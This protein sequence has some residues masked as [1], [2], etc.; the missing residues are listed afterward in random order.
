MLVLICMGGLSPG[1]T[2]AAENPFNVDCFVGWNGCYRPGTWTPLE[3]GITSTLTENFDGRVHVSV[4]QDSVNRMN[5]TQSFVLTVDQPTHIPLVTKIAFGADELNL[6]LT[7]TRGRVRRRLDIGLWDFSRNNQLLKPVNREDLFV[8]LVGRQSFG[9]LRLPEE[10]QCVYSGQSRTNFGRVFVESKLPHMVPWDWT[11]F[12]GLDLLILYDPDWGRFRSEQV[13][14]ITDWVARG[15]KLLVVLGTFPFPANNLLGRQLPVTIGALREIA[16]STAWLGRW[17]LDA[18]RVQ[19]AVCY[20]LAA[21][22]EAHV[23]TP[24]RANEATLF[25]AGQLG[26]GRVGVLG[27]DPAALDE[28]QRDRAYGFWVCAFNQLLEA[29]SDPT[30]S[31]PAENRRVS[32]NPRNRR[33]YPNAK[34][35]AATGNSAQERR[36]IR[37]AQAQET[38]ENPN[39]NRYSYDMGETQQGTGRVLDYLAGIQEMRPLSIGWVILLLLLLAV[40]LGPVD[41]MVLKRLDR[42]PLTWVTSIF[43]IVVFTVGAYYGVQALRA[44][45]MQLRTVSVVDGIQDRG[46]AWTT[47]V[48]GLFAP[49]SADYQLDQLQSG[50]WWSA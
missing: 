44:G 10:T 12:T 11:G 33:V 29:R 15:G 34:L 49:K 36:S 2:R 43:W 4:A 17:D 24:P 37:L 41:Y 14:A 38:Q 5:I 47:Q 18:T 25:A 42:Q 20:E 21:R 13:K 6:R 30:E 40:L 23:Y 3:I 32:R 48:C 27:L 22:P 8:G 31:V 28:S 39:R 16:L 26:F 1:A 50:Q 7:D 35:Q 9:L 19:R 46:S 45:D